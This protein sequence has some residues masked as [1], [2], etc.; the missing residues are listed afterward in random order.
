MNIRDKKTI[1][2]AS[3]LYAVLSG[4]YCRIPSFFSGDPPFWEHR[5]PWRKAISF[6]L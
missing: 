2:L 1:T 3:L 6:P 4:L 5:S